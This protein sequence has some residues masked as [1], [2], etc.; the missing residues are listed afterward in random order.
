MA[1]HAHLKKEVTEDEKIHNLV[2]WLICKKKNAAS[3][4]HQQHQKKKEL[5]FKLLELYMFIF[6][7]VE[8]CI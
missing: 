1:A 8:L 2:T 4:G 7:V 3:A 5:K 6:Q